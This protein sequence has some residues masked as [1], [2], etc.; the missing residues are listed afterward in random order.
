MSKVV[1]LV[2]IP[3][4]GKTTFAKKYKGYVRISQDELGDRYKCLE[5][6]RKSLSEKKNVIID[7]CN[8][9]K[10]QRALFIMIAKEYGVTDI[11][12]INLVI[13]PET[14]IKRAMERKNHPTIKD[15]PLEKVQSIVYSFVKT[16]EAPTLDEGFK[17]ILFMDMN[18]V[19]NF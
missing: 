6:L 9:N 11:N 14:A 7:R 5:L 8:V 10:M 15:L 17:R 18:E 12:C 13:D 19:S 3:G 2:S 1:I 4:A 16:Y